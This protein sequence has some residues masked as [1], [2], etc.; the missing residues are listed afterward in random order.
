M[1][2]QRYM[3]GLR[4]GEIIGAIAMTEPSGGSDL[5]GMRTNAVRKRM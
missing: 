5:Q 3:P 4:D 1:K 2:F